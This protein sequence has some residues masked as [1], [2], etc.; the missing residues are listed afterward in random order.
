MLEE[1]ITEPASGPWAAPVVIVLKASGEPRICIDYRGLNQVTIKDRYPLPRVDK[2]LDFLARGKFISTID[3]ARGYWQVGVKESSRPK[4]VFASHCGL[5]QFKVLPFSLCN[6]PATFQRL[7][8][9]VLAGLVYTCCTV[10]LDNVVIASPTFE[11]HL[12]DLGQVFSRLESAGVSL[13]LGKCQFYLDE[14][15]FLGYRVTP[16]GIFPDMD[17]LH[18]DA[19]DMGLGAALMQQDKTGKEVVVAYASRTLHK[20]EKPYSTT[21]KECLAVIWALEHFRPY[22]EGLPVTVYT[23]HSSLRWLMSRP[24]LTGQLVRW[25]LRLQDFDIRIIHKPG[26]RNQVPDALS[27]NPVQS[28]QVPT[29]LLP[30]HVVIA[31][32]DLRAQ[33]PVELTDKE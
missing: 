13:K 32:L 5:F 33:P 19:C 15:K 24:N 28:D 29:D 1:D 31:G 26:A 20:S 14:L 11:Q 21:E 8:N 16:Q 30:E 7:M 3:L 22:I 27:R 9:T 4:T 6:S 10:Y 23:D 17:K 18:T 12:L 25:C 2:S